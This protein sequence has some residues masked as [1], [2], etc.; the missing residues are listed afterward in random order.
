MA[1]STS[2]IAVGLLILFSLLF[3]IIWLYALVDCLRSEFRRSGDKVAWLLAV[4]FL[5]ILGSVLYLAF[6]KNTK[7]YRIPHANLQTR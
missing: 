2:V 4:I 5:P 3:L 6:S 1:S 7:L